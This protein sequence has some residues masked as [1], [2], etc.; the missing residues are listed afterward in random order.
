MGQSPQRLATGR[1]VQG[2]NTSDGEIFRAVR[3]G[4]EA[5]AFSCKIGTGSF[6]GVGGGRQ[7]GWSVMLINHFLLA[8]GC[9]WV[10]AIPP[11]PPVLAQPCHGVTFTLRF[12]TYKYTRK[13]QQQL[14]PSCMPSKYGAV[15]TVFT[16]SK[17]FIANWTSLTRINRKNCKAMQ[18]SMFGICVTK[19]VPHESKY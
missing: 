9:E 17:S 2:S 4:P 16:V 6:L 15:F 14:C 12:H 18:N 13:Q 5:R 1:M 8:A 10:G 19:D 7:S 3:T 11:L